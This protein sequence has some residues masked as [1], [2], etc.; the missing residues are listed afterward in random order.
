MNEIETFS[1]GDMKKFSASEQQ[2]YLL[3]K[4]FGA[5]SVLELTKK[6]KSDH[7]VWLVVSRLNKK[8]AREKISTLTI[9]KDD[10]V[11]YYLEKKNP[12]M[13]E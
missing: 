1:I 12:E 10:H 13:I 6:F 9:G 2:L 3:L 7:N 5:H 8:L 11:S 4:N